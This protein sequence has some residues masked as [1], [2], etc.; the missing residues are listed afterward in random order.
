MVEEPMENEEE[1][2]EPRSRTLPERLQSWA[3][4][5]FVL[6]ASQDWIV[7]AETVA[8]IERLLNRR[9]R[10]PRFLRPRWIRFVDITGAAVRIELDSIYWIK[11]ST[12]SSREL[13][14]RFK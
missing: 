10:R 6:R 12:P 11:Q 13:W 3:P 4:E 5:Y 1:R 14:R 9:W 7:S 2:P 8:W